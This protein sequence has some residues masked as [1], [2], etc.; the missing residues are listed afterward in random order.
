MNKDITERFSNESNLFKAIKKQE[1]LLL[2]QP[3][4]DLKSN[5]ITGFESLVRW[6]SPD[7]GVLSPYKF[8]PIAEETNLIIPLGEWIIRETCKQNKKWRERQRG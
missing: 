7:K 6:N 3:Q 1:F 2:F 8:I 4:I 5:E